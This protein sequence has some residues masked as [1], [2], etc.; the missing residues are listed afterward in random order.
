VGATCC[1]TVDFTCGG[2]TATIDMCVE[3][4]QCPVPVTPG[5]WGDIKVL[6]R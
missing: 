3:A 5:T 2:V 1:F 4:C 6:Y